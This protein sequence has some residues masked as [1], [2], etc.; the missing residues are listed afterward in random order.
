MTNERVDFYRLGS[1]LWSIANIFRDDTLKTTEYLEEFSYFLFLKMFDDQEMQKE[2]MAKLDGEKYITYL[3]DDLRFYNWAGKVVDNEIPTSEIVPTVK[4]IFQQLSNIRDHDE[5]DLS[6]FRRLFR[7][8]I[9]RIRY[10]PTIRELLKR[11]MDLELEH[12]F[13]VMGRAY[14]FIVQKLGEQKQYGQ[15]FTP[16]HI[17]HFMIELAD[18]E[19]EETIYDPAAGTGGF[20]LRSFEV[21]KCKIEKLTETSFM[22]LRESTVSYGGVEFDRAEK[23]LRDLKGKNLFA[24]EKA[25]DVYKLALMNMILHND[26]NTNLYEADSLDN[27]A[28]VEHREKYDVVLT[29]L[30]T[31]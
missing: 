22:G 5:K 7:N 9:W 16:R 27:R 31:M 30:I 15:Y 14:E 20:I 6:L 18:P 1:E 3:P 13:D 11:L 29:H 24:V 19:I 2:E 21:I 26:G 4:N 12:N 28:Q 8:H 25:P 17:I 10:I 23:L